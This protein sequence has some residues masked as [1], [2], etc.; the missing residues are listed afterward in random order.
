MLDPLKREDYSPD[1][2]RWALSHWQDLQEAA[3]GGTG[4]LAGQGG[5]NGNRLGLADLLADLEAAADQLPLDWKPTLQ[6]FL[7]QG[8]GST[9]R[10]RRLRMNDDHS[11]DEVIYRMARG[12]G[13]EEQDG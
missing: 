5:G 2:I 12:L 9:W 4:S 1:R 8:R 13:W 11:L 6:V 7:A 10:M 3:E